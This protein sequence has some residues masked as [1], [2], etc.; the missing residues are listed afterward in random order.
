MSAN[1]SVYVPNPPPSECGDVVD[2]GLYIR[3]ISGGGWGGGTDGLIPPIT[4]IV[5]PSGDATGIVTG[6]TKR[7]TLRLVDGDAIL[8]HRPEGDWLIGAS[9]ASWANNN[10]LQLHDD[11]FGM[12]MAE[13]LGHGVCEDMGLSEAVVTLSQRQL[14]NTAWHDLSVYAKRIA[15]RTVSND[16]LHSISLRLL[17]A[18]KRRQPDAYLARLHEM[19]RK[20]DTEALR[21]S[22]LAAMRIIAKA[23]AL[24]L[25]DTFETGN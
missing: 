24:W 25:E 13:R 15:A 6:T 14:S 19:I 8:A 5:P 3:G 11:I 1:D 2:E 18:W 12:P 7:S 22:I 21:P 20:P 4:P 10:W 17:S 16:G 9:R 23:D